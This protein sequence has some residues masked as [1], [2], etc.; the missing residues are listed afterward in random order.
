[1]KP[2]TVLGLASLAAAFGVAAPNAQ[3][4]YLQVNG[5]CVASVSPGCASDLQTVPGASQLTFNQN[6]TLGDG[7]TYNVSGTAFVDTFVGVSPNPPFGPMQ[8]LTLNPEF[9]VQYIDPGPSQADTLTFLFSQDFENVAFSGGSFTNF[10]TGFTA[11]HLGDGSSIQM[12]NTIGT[13]TFAALTSPLSSSFDQQ[14]DETL[15]TLANPLTDSIAYTMFIGSGSEPGFIVE[16]P[17]P[18][19]LALLGAG[20][21]ALGAARRRPL[22]Q[23]L[24]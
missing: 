7:D 17:A 10:L 18:A 11:G 21:L 2:W 6:I 4:A 9:Q 16:V 12:V 22:R 14:Q 15:S 19:S 1:M 8:V 20:V 5:V 24:R 13:T 23:V 3:A